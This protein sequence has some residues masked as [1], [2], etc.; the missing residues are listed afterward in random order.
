MKKYKAEFKFSAYEEE[1]A[2]IQ[3]NLASY[4][5]GWFWLKEVSAVC[6]FDVDG[7]SGGAVIQKRMS[8]LQQ[9]NKIL[10]ADNECLTAE[11]EALSENIKTQLEKISALRQEI[12]VLTTRNA[13]LQQEVS[14]LTDNNA[15]L[16]EFSRLA[17]K[18]SGTKKN[19]NIPVGIDYSAR[20]CDNGL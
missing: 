1:L 11:K 20:F 14:D 8:H 7:D 16:H 18:I 12:T 4:L 6:V 13:L 17:D 3:S 5:Y 9:E 2:Y 10:S 15:A 19:I